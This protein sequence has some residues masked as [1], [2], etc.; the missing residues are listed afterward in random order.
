MVGYDKKRLSSYLESYHPSSLRWILFA[1]FFKR[2]DK[3]RII[4]KR[5]FLL[6]VRDS[7]FQRDPFE[8]VNPELTNFHIFNGVE[9]IT[10]EQC[11]WN[12][13]WVK[14]CFGERM[15]K[16]IGHNHI[17]CSGV[18]VGTMD[19]VYEYINI[20]KE[21]MNGGKGLS[22]DVKQNY[23]KL[24]QSPI[25]FPQCER[26]GVDQGVHNVVIY[27]GYL[28]KLFETNKESL[29]KQWNQKDTPVCNMQAKV[30]Q[31]RNSQ[32]DV[33]NT[34]GEIV[35]VVHQYDRFPELQKVL[36]SKVILS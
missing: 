1:D 2:K 31:I 29:I 35:H 20:M 34:K 13:G 25:L 28:E 22:Q 11:G 3:Y 15:L 8:F 36:F 26:N 19:V 33:I 7:Y 4:F 5:C 6:D 12:G 10:I 24:G 30:C 16:Q 17:I 14:S 21:I 27:N 23:L 32:M 18:S 9:T